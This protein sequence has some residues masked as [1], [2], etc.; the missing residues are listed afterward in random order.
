MS[1]VHLA[2]LC[3]H[4]QNTSK[5]RLGLTSIPHTHMLLTISLLL[6][7]SG[8]ISSVTRGTIHGPDESYTPTT[9][10]NISK[11]RL[12][13]GLKYLDN[14]PVLNQAHLVSKPTKRIWVGFRDLRELT[15][16]RDRCY[17]KGLQPG[18]VLFVSTDRG[19][20]EAREAVERL[21]GG[22]LLVR[23]S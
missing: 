20:M 6:Q 17:V 7:R 14:E 13:L 22:Q 5:A 9:Q 19:V 23:A 18:E 21:L 8:F 3:S 11:R 1:L 12:W 10:S 15:M 2:N 16:G 4:L